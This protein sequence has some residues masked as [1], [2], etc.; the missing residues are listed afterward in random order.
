MPEW[1]SFKTSNGVLDFKG[2]FPSESRDHDIKIRIIGQGGVILRDI[3]L[4]RIKTK[5]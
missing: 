4:V 5:E 1:L 2:V 3:H